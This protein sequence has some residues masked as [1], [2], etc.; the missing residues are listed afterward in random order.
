MKAVAADCTLE[1]S[2]QTAA[3][4]LVAVE[5]EAVV[6]LELLPPQPAMSDAVSAAMTVGRAMAWRT[7]F[8]YTGRDLIRD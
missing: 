2:V 6:R 5:V 4:A 8:P 3:L 7:G 1:I